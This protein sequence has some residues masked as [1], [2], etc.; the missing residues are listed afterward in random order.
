MK[1]LSDEKLVYLVQKYNDKKAFEALVKRYQ[2]IV[3]SKAMAFV[4]N[5]EDAKDISQEI[6][7]KAYFG[8]KKFKGKSS[9]NTWLY[10]IAVNRC[11]TF[12]KEKT[13]VVSLD[14]IPQVAGETNL[15]GK[16][17]TKLSVE[18]TLGHINP[19]QKVLLLAKYVEGYSYKE[20]AGIFDSKSD[21]IKMEVFRAKKTFENLYEGS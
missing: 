2:N 11:L 3:Y 20:L 8:L 9:F 18:N 14:N 1:N 7:V 4:G 15:E 5:K 13:E 6:F 17:L 12:V 10:R 16:S 19:R 21:A